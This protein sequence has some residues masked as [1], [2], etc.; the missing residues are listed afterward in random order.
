MDYTQGIIWYIFWPIIIIVSVKFVQHNL[1]YF[2]KL[3]RLE[4]YEKKYGKDVEI[5]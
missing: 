3:E 2:K 1:Q 5:E 4:A